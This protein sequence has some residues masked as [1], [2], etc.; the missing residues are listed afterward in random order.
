MQSVV[1]RVDLILFFFTFGALY[2][3]LRFRN[4]FFPVKIKF[5]GEKANVV[6]D[7]DF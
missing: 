5:Y 6:Q 4:F 3:K 1:S 7:I 2:Y